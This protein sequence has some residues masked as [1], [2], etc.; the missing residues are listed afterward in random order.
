MRCFP[1]IIGEEQSRA[2]RGA[3]PF[4]RPRALD[5]EFLIYVVAL[6]SPRG[7]LPLDG[8]IRMEQE[9]LLRILKRMDV[10]TNGNNSI[11]PSSQSLTR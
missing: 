7:L 9:L 10:M 8:A 2:A 11:R 5:V 6:H 4:K 1:K 3:A